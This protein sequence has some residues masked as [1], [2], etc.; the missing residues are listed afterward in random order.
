MADSIFNTGSL[1]DLG[2]SS[3]YMSKSGVDTMFRDSYIGSNTACTY[4][5]R[6][7]KYKVM[8]KNDRVASA[9]VQDAYVCDNCL[10]MGYLDK[11]NFG[12]RAI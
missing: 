11:K 10:G 6:P 2:V 3:G 7:G 4:C 9:Q 8:P 12:I 1:C 5:G